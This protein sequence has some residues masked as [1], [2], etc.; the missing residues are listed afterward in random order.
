[1]RQNQNQSENALGSQPKSSS[2]SRQASKKAYFARNANGAISNRNRDKGL[3][4]RK[5]RAE[6]WA[7]PEGRARKAEKM[8]APDKVARRAASLKA[9]DARRRE[10]KMAEQKAEKAPKVSEKGFYSND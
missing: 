1:M 8:S 4:R 3:A 2:K 10:R 7:S 5:R 6:Y 9:R